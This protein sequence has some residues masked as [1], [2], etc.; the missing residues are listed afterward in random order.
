MTFVH[1]FWS[2]PLLNNKFEKFEMMLPVILSNYAYSA[3][4]IKQRGHKIKLYADE[5]GAEML[6]FIPYDSIEII[7]NM[8]DNCVHFAAQIKFEALKRMSLDEY[9]IDG[10][11][12]L[13]K[14]QVFDILQTTHVDFLYSFYEPNH[15]V[16]KTTQDPKRYFDLTQTLLKHK[17]KFLEGYEIYTEHDSY[18]WPNTSLMRFENQDLKDEYIAQYE[19]HKGILK[20]ETFAFWPD[21]IVEQQHMEQLVRR[22]GYSFRPVLYGFPSNATNDYASI[23][24]YCHLGGEKVNL[25]QLTYDWLL[26]ENPELYNKVF[27]KE[28]ELL[29]KYK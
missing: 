16:I 21:V 13:R 5:K 26:K 1:S 17:D 22:K 29:E 4:C 8:D 20:D 9:L 28:K 27:E 24:G 12:F 7:P 3:H 23:I 25:K 14:P 18:H 15:F 19:Y 6:D 10:D 11:L 2:K